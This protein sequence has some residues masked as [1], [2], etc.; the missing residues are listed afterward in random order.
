MR[1]MIAIEKYLNVQRCSMKKIL[2]QREDICIRYLDTEFNDLEVPRQEL[3]A[4]S[5]VGQV[6]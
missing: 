6:F 4:G 3:V 1:K 2:K 5:V